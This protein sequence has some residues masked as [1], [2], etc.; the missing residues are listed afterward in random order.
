MRTLLI[1]N[2]FLRARP[3]LDAARVFSIAVTAARQGQ[4]VVVVV[5]D[6]PDL[7]TRDHKATELVAKGFAAEG[8]AVVK[9]AAVRTA[10]ATP[11]K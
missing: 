10:A 3:V 5:L 11:G 9:T 7:K 6:S 4:R 1:R 2:C 8:T